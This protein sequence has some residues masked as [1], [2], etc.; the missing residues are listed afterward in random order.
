MK[1]T[2]WKI[3]AQKLT[4]S[5]MARWAACEH[6]NYLVYMSGNINICE[7]SDE[8]AV[9]GFEKSYLERTK[10]DLIGVLTKYDELMNR[11]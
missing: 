4:H 9:K 1:A 5:Q 10:E 3:E 7:N 6:I 8:E 2:N 11:K